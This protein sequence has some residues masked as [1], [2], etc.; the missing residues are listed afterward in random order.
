MTSVSDTYIE[1]RER[2]QPND[3]NNYD[4]AHGG[5]IMKWMDE[6]GAI[7]AMRLAGETCVTAHV[8][9][10]DF[11]RPIPRG[12]ICV[13]EAYAY[14]T[15]RSSIRVR[16]QAHRENPRTGERERTTDSYFVFVAVDDEG[17]PTPVPELVVESARC[18][19]LRE[20]AL[21]GESRD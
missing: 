14:A 9:N 6:V 11:E 1:N 8:N 20:A 4:S 10:L 17:T 12:D 15:G 2:V 21:S 13:V 19:A 5:N 7:C 16:L 18:Q 3:T